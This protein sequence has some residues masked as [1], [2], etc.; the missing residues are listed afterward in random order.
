VLEVKL[1]GLRGR[2]VKH[3]M[4]HAAEAGGVLTP[5]GL[6][7]LHGC[8]EGAYG[9][10]LDELPRRVLDMMFRRVTLA[11]AARGERL[12]CDL[13][14]V[15]RGAAGGG[16]RLVDDAVILE[17]KSV[18]GGAH[19]D[20]VLRDLGARPV[21]TCS[22]YCVGIALTRPEVHANPFWPLL[23]RYFVAEPSA[24]SRQAARAATSAA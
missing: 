17:S 7:F 1:K 6:A 9:P 12:T 18:R 10:A 4:A 15:F 16:G 2:T 19:A 5:P 8:L 14:L 20:R 24:R 3:R 22:K 11:D 23:R 21:T 13:G